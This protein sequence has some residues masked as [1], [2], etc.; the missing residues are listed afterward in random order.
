MSKIYANPFSWGEPVKGN[1]YV[2]RP[3]DQ[4][5]I[6]SS[7][8]NQIYLLLSGPRGIG[9]TSLLTFTL[10]KSGTPFIHLDLRFIVKRVELLDLLLRA[11]ETSFPSIKM[12]KGF[13]A[14]IDDSANANL[15]KIFDLWYESVK[16]SSKKFVIA[17]DE[18]QHLAKFKEDIIG[19][20]KVCLNGRR[21]ITHMFVTHRKDILVD[22]FGANKQA[23]FKNQEY[24]ELGNLEQKACT[25]Y[26][27]KRFRRMGLSDFDLPEAVYKITAGQ[28]LF[29]QR[30]SYTISQIWLEGTTTRLLQR[31]HTKLLKERNILF[32]ALWDNFGLNEKRL[33]L[34]LASGYSRPTEL[35]FIAKFELSATSTAHNTVLK[36]VKEGWLVNR[37]EGYHI[38][39]PLFLS[40]L[41]NR[42][43]LI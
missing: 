37:D 42:E 27:S 38:Y 41:Q 20:L 29:T 3:D 25:S 13:K 33:L 28:P 16:G 21:G 7:I 5:V 22:E 8:E 9:K 10:D 31:S 17:W 30:L 43:G 23:F 39:D 26:L 2:Q 1:H 4:A 34:G 6:L 15:T 18:F 36:L 14:L 19:E 11:L 32:T 12:D 24:F 40:W 35:E